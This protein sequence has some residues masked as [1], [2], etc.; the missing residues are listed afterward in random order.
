MENRDE[1]EPLIVHPPSHDFNARTKKKKNGGP[2]KG[3]PLG[4]SS[5]RTDATVREF[6]LTFKV[7]SPSGRH[8]TVPSI[9]ADALEHH[10]VNMQTYQLPHLQ[11]WARGMSEESMSV[12]EQMFQTLDGS[13]G[14][15]PQ[16]T[17]KKLKELS[18]RVVRSKHTQS[19]LQKPFSIADRA[20]RQKSDRKRLRKGTGR[21]R[22]RPRKT[23][24]KRGRASGS[25]APGKSKKSKTVHEV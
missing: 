17:L 18:G 21:G 5:H 2:E 14:E 10:P 22:G 15:N 13:E 12:V 19:S 1:L 25:T 16:E 6:D 24:K 9:S 3:L 7:K 23:S 20:K 8:T 11:R 4:L